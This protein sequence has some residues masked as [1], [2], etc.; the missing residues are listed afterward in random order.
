MAI[1]TRALVIIG[2]L[3]GVLALGALLLMGG[4]AWQCRCS[5]RQARLEQGQQ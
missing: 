2:V 4:L 1:L 3:A 5:E